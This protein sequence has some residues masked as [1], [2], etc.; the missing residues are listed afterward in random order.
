MKNF[1][2][3]AFISFILLNTLA[4][5]AQVKEIPNTVFERC[6]TMGPFQANLDRDPQFKAQYEKGLRD[7]DRSLQNLQVGRT[8]DAMRTS[9]LPDSVIIPV[10]VHIVLPN[11]G[12]VTDADVQFFLDRLN[13]DFSGRNQD[14]A[15]GVLFYNV[16]GHSKIRFALARRT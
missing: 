14:S 8:F 3:L 12:I 16:R 5:N 4:L 6:G 9:A 13:R 7:Y 10:V 11:P 15:N 2:F 1:T